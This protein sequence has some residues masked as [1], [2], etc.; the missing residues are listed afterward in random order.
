M[1]AD[2]AVRPPPGAARDSAQTAPI[3]HDV[4]RTLLALLASALGVFPLCELFTDRGWMIDVWLTM[5]VVV[6]PAAVLRQRRTAS[7]PQIWIGVALL[8][9]WLTLN[10]VRRHAVLGI[11]PFH[12]AWHDVGRLMTDLHATTTDQVAPVHTTV[13]IRL[14]ICALLGLVAALVDLLAVVG[15]RGALAGVPL[16]VVFTVSGAV[17][18]RPV[19]WL[20]FAFSAAGFLILLA[21]DSSDDLQRWGHYVPRAYRVGRRRAAGLVSGQRIA[22]AAIALA[23]MVP[24][25]IPSNSRNFV[26]NLF[27]PHKVNG[28]GDFGANGNSGSGSGGIDPFAALRGQ[29]NRDRSTDLL[30]V[31]VSS[32][33]GNIGAPGH[34][35]P[36]YLRTNVLT[37]FTGSGWVAGKRGATEPVSR[38][39]FPSKPGTPFQPEVV[40]Y[41]ADIAVTGLRSNPP[42]FGS[43]TAVQGVDK[44][45]KWSPQDMLLVGSIT[46]TG[47]AFHEDVAQPLPSVATLRSATG[48][49]SA[50][51]DSLK[52]PPIRAYV[53]QLTDRIT[54]RATTPYAK[55]RA[56]SN[57]FAD[58]DSGFLYSLQ[59]TNGD[60]GDDLSDF[61][62]NRTGFCQQ[63]AAAMGV[64]L[65]LSGVPARVVLGYAHAVPDNAGTFDVT[66]FDAHAWVEAYFSGVGWVPFD[67]TPLA[68]I[69]GGADSDLAWAPH[70]KIFNDRAPTTRGNPNDVPSAKPTHTSAA[71]PRAASGGS[72]LSFLLPIIALVL[73]L[74]GAA[75][76]VPAAVRQVRRRRRLRLAHRGDTDALWAELSDTATDLG[77]VWSAAR[78]PRQVAG[79]LGG[80]SDAATSSLRTLTAAVEQARY[81]PTGEPGGA[82]LV[83]D[84]HVVH[85][86][87]RSRRSGRE[88]VRAVLWPAS[89][90]WAQIRWIGWIGQWLPGRRGRR[91]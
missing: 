54:A 73:A 72:G 75:L 59:T 64:M 33:S 88:R 76:L 91:T 86:G 74:I 61:L 39:Q 62:K 27:H 57:F 63:Y 80:S 10:F 9:P 12:G 5:A 22:A 17:P 31:H 25:F 8:I 14:A 23:V 70:G 7:A 19:S 45:T 15:R 81:A 71:R 29:L 53:R 20:W 84:L 4:R 38:T 58:P 47:E 48:R 11:L 51:A 16:L 67:P 18:R 3:S 28:Q 82:D 36:F 79:W 46:H 66:T 43:P 83:H 55:A 1:S 24:V 85:A 6:A 89:L 37:K 26:S 21:L 65:R 77:Y 56:I 34:A 50:M 35:Q 78:T 68:G 41:S 87:L 90:R 42:I 52:L 2:T 13:A 30:T 60:S 69:S 49:D 44:S 40:R 32:G